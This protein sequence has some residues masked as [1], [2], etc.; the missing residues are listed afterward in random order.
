M[1]FASGVTAGGVHTRHGPFCVS[2]SSPLQLRFFFA[3]VRVF[4]LAALSFALQAVSVQS[5]HAL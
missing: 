1:P 4:A 2:V 3:Q 5:K